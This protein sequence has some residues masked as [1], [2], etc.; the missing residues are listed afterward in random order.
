M[1]KIIIVT[2]SAVL[3]AV[4]LLTAP[5]LKSDAAGIAAEEHMND[6]SLTSISIPSG[7][8]AIGKR[9][10]YGCSN[11]SSVIIPDGVT[12]IGESAFAMCTQLANIQIPPSVKKIEPGAFAGD[13][14][15]QTLSFE[16]SNYNFFYSDGVLYNPSSN[17]IISYL[18]G[19][20]NAEYIMP[21]SV[22]EIDKYAFWG[23]NYLNKVTV[24]GSVKTISPYDFAYCSGLRY[25]FLPSSVK[26]IQ[27]YAFRDCISLE[28]VYA[29]N[30]S[31]KI[32]DYAFYN[33]SSGMN[34]V[35]GASLI[36]FNQKAVIKTPETSNSDSSQD[37]SVI[38][39]TASSD[40]SDMSG[41][42]QDAG[43]SSVQTPET[44]AQKKARELTERLSGPYR[45][46]DLPGLIGYSYILDG[47]AIVITDTSSGNTVSR[48][49]SAG[50]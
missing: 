6:D 39:S 41:K 2:A 13:K 14:A 36:A 7:T 32:D 9:A 19:N 48:N 4:V 12:T 29:E 20:K 44:E 1:K 11:L 24:S 23:A 38:A 28:D 8:T 15:L 47:K 46:N 16:G 34:T 33:C 27:E 49:T 5:A 21:S 10:Y 45:G 43:T 3:I 22:T 25:I 37:Q 26:S 31:V 18:P 35:S 30:R 50:K 42:S 40:G 17:E